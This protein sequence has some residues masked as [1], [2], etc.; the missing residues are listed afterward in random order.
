MEAHHSGKTN[1]RATN[2]DRSTR[3]TLTSRELPCLAFVLFTSKRG[4]DI[5]NLPASAGNQ[6]QYEPL[7]YAGIGCVASD[8]EV[9]S[10]RE[11]D[12]R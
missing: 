5:A 3:K 6:L 8:H 11:F 1:A 12:C 10:R 9:T 4:E 2:I 7:W